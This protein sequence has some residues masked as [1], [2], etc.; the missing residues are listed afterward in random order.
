[1]P[2]PTFVFPQYNA[3]CFA[4]LP[5][6][7]H[8]LLTGTNTSPLAPEILRGL[9]P[10][11]EKVILFFIDALGWRF[12]EQYAAHPFLQR[13]IQPGRLHKLTSQFPSTTAA[14]VT[15][16]HSGL[17]VA[18][19][20]LVEWHYYEPQLDA[21]ITPLMF[22]F[23]GDKERETLTASRADPRQLYP[24]RTLYQQ[25]GVPSVILQ[26]REYTPSTYSNQLFQGAEVFGYKALAEALATLTQLLT[27]RPGPGYYF[28]YFD[29]VDSV[30][31]DHGPN[32]LQVEAEILATLD[33]LERWASRRLPRAL[34]LL[35]ADHG[36]VEVDPQTTHYLNR[37]AV[38]PTIA[39]HLK[40]N[41]AGNLLV[42]AGAPRDMFLYV[43]AEAVA[44]VHAE[45]SRALE[46][47]AVVAQA[48]DLAAEGW[49]GPATPSA[50]FWGRMGQLIILPFRGESV[51]LYEPGHYEMPYFGH[52]GGLTPQEME[53]PLGLLEL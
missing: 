25:L 51:W 3:R 45:L 15:C 5:A 1:M 7:V 34:L 32:S 18:H 50:A 22:S 4:D 16:I 23:T 30:C 53:I 9:A 33:A 12:I 19:S 2:H 40:R 24:T 42:P 8:S 52:H 26:S 38:W 47:V 35:T 27:T 48:K 21:L 49:F 39:P 29:K 31:H 10:Q 14:H 28:L 13:F 41:R 11:Y 44:D 37:L 46:G 20:G 17:P 36:Q 6:T 43:N